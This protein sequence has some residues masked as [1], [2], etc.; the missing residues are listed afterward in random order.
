MMGLLQ[1]GGISCY[2][3]GSMWSCV[4][5]DLASAAGGEVT[6]GLLVGGVLLLAF[7]I[8]GDGEIATPSVLAILLV[9]ILLPVLPGS[10]RQMATGLMLMGVVGGLFALARRYVLQVGT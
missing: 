5:Q 4:A 2:Q 1:T 10:V 8:A 9:G 7:Y 6:F 3:S